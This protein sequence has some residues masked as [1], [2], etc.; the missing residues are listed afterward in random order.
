MLSTSEESSEAPSRT[1]SRGSSKYDDHS[2]S[3]EG[4]QDTS[5][6]PGQGRFVNDI[7]ML[8]D[9][10]N[11][12]QLRNEFSKVAEGLT[13]EEFVYVMKRFVL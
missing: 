8:L 11:V 2:S 7:M 6:I 10:E 9:T 3:M 5:R 13:L 1:P 12:Q 4:P